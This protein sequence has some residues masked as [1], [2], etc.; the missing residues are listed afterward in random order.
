MAKRKHFDYC[1]FMTESSGIKIITK[2]QLA[3][4]LG[5]SPSTIYRMIKSG[6]LPPPLRSPKGYIQGWLSGTI[7]MWQSDHNQY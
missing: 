3:E 5:V 7:E 6:L 2:S 1:R 4:S